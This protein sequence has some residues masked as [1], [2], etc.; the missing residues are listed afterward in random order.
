MHT[1]ETDADF[2]VIAVEHALTA[3]LGTPVEVA[4]ADERTKAPK[5]KRFLRAS[6]LSHTF[7][8]GT[9]ESGLSERM[10]V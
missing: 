5:M 9:L 8:C 1:R 2:L 6:P 10:I 3:G 4:F 7:Y